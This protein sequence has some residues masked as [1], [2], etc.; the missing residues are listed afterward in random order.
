ME[1]GDVRALDFADAQVADPAPD[2]GLGIVAVADDRAGF[3]MLGGMLVDDASTEVVDGEFVPGFLTGASRIVTVLHSAENLDR[4]SARLLC[5]ED[6]VE[7]EAHAPELPSDA[8]LE[9]VRAFAAG[10]NASA[11]AGDF[12]VE[13]DVVLVS[14]FCGLNK[15][16][17]DLGHGA[18]AHSPGG[19]D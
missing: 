10:Q 6:V 19:F 15:A 2:V 13:N 14:N 18:G 5:C 11:E 17:G 9:K 4:F 7:T 12:A 8:I 16:F 3:A 1:L